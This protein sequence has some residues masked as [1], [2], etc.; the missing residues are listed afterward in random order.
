MLDVGAI[1]DAG[2]WVTAVFTLLLMLEGFRREWWVPGRVYRREVKRGDDAVAA[3]RQV[4]SASEQVVRSG[5]RGDVDPDG[6]HH[7]RGTDAS[8]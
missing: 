8:A 3:A 5:S 6:S 2:G 7:R 4:A 1:A